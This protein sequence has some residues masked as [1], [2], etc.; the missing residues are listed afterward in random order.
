VTEG[1][2]VRKYERLAQA[3]AARYFGDHAELVQL[4][5]I[6]IMKAARTWSPRRGDF[7]LWAWVCAIQKVAEFFRYNQALKRRTPK[8]FAEIDAECVAGPNGVCPEDR[9]FL[10]RALAVLNAKDRH[11]INL[12][13]SGEPIAEIAR[14]FYVSP[15]GMHQ[16]LKA[17][18]KKMRAAAW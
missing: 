9:V 11:I 3:V 2:I 18:F 14:Q 12:Y 17:I 10:R 7:T 8:G 1:K 13:A 4:A 16:R 6:G 5:R 15:Q